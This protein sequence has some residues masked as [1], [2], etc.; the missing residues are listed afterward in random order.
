LILLLREK[1]IVLPPMVILQ[2]SSLL[3]RYFCD[4]P[5]NYL[6]GTSLSGY[7][8]DELT[9]AWVKHF[10]KFS[11][12]HM[13]GT[14]RLLLFDGF[15]LHCTA[16]F[17]EVLEDNNIT[18]YR[19]PAHIS[20]FLQPLDVGY[21]QPYKHWHAEAVDAATRT[22]CTS[23]NKVKFLHAIESIRHYTFKDKTIR[24]GWRDTSLLPPNPSLIL[25][26][27]Q[28]DDMFTN[29]AIAYFITKLEESRQYVITP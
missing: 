11:R 5:D 17:L 9:L 24:R 3:K 25:H 16:E 19:L 12:K 10:E 29:Y 21:F 15:D 6:V 2:G 20:H 28:K 27:I 23:F 4:L 18:P 1:E 13:K 22:G 7:T 8:N 26:N 14:K